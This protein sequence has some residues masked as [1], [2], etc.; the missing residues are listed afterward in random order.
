MASL[1]HRGSTPLGYKLAAH[2]LRR[3]TYKINKS[4]IDYFATLNVDQ[5]LDE[6]LN[7]TS[8]DTT[9]FHLP[10]PIAYDTGTFFIN[11]GSSDLNSGQLRYIVSH[12]YMDEARRSPNLRFKLGIFLHSIFITSSVFSLYKLNFD[13]LKWLLFYSKESYKDLS[14]K[15][16]YDNRMLYYLHN[17]N[18]I[19]GRPNEDYAREFLELFTITKGEQAGPGDYTNYTEQD[20]VEAARLLTGFRHQPDR[21]IIDPDTGI[22][23]GYAN[24]GL[25]DTGTK[26]FSHRFNNQSISGAVDA[27]DMFRELQD[28][29]DM[30]FDQEET[31]KVICRRMYRFFVRK[32]ID[33]E[34]ENDIIAPLAT[35][36]R[37]NNYKLG[38]TIRTLM[39]SQHFYD[40]D[41]SNSE[42]EIVG[43]LVKNPLDLLLQSLNLLEAEIADPETEAYTHYL[44]Y[45][46]SRH[47][48]MNYSEMYLFRPDT[49]A[50]YKAIYQE[51]EFDKQWFNFNTINSRYAIG[52][53]ILHGKRY[54]GPY[55]G[56]WEGVS[57][58]VV[59]F[60]RNSGNFLDPSNA[61]I[62]IEEIYALL[63]IETP[64]Q[65]RHEYFYYEAFLQ[66]LSPINWR[67]EW[68]TYIGGGSDASVRGHLES[69]F[70]AVMSSTEYQVL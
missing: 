53:S 33:S 57:F 24:Y 49:V 64:E 68:N 59:D 61:E 4:R 40:E 52:K 5:A 23:T 3:A 51:P 6:L 45:Y 37:T 8:F 17:L 35:V 10:E 13:Y 70:E 19:K 63:L 29:V 44:S 21:T 34:V 18:N 62:F 22:P 42:D 12:W 14:F 60:V 30:V 27:D 43:A 25:H 56:T 39:S 54:F 36:L 2:L 28:Y 38:I 26:I 69:I 31:A 50:G 47:E 66:N 58:D 32:E 46:R 16:T 11:S 67:N 55:H 41:D 20:V 7:Y 48:F 15:I 65:Y 1:S 9:D